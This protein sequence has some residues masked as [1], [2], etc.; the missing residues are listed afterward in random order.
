MRIAA[1]LEYDGSHFSGWQVQAT[2]PQGETVRT[3]QA[4][5]ERALSAVADESVRVTVAGR[6]DAG[7]NACAQVVH[8]DTTAPRKA[9]A[10]V[11]GTNTHLPPDIAVLWAGEV[12]ESFH[13]RYSATG[14]WYRYLIF[15]RGVRPTYLAQRVTWE[16]RPLDVGRMQQAAIHLVGQHD[17]SA[18]RATGCQAKSPVRD[19]RELSVARHGEIIAIT[20]HANAF[21]HHMVRNIAGVL[22]AIGAGEREPMWAGEVL[23]GR[24]RRQGGVTAPPDGLYLM[25]VDYPE[26]YG[27]PRLP[28]PCGLW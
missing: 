3:I 24:D 4:A 12:D 21:L 25:A 7:V 16:Y 14:R 13:A 11:R 10:W 18:F 1:V 28:S 26:T 2:Y 9:Q 17:F 5:V 22:I 23:Q 19:L 15:N 8:F 6:T 20:A 27:L